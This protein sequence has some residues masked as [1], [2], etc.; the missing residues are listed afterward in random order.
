M[1]DLGVL[2]N[3]WEAPGYLILLAVVDFLLVL[4]TIAHWMVDV[5][6]D[7]SGEARVLPQVPLVMAH[8]EDG[9]ALTIQLVVIVYIVSECPFGI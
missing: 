2:F 4:L 6:V 7:D 3:H 9:L 8:S 5:L 1:L